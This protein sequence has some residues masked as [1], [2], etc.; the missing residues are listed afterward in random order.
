MDA[1]AIGNTRANTPSAAETARALQPVKGVPQSDEAKMAAAQNSPSNLRS[2]QNAQILQASMDVSIKSANTSL[3][4]LYRTAID[5]IN[6]VL[7]LSG[8]LEMCKERFLHMPE[9]V[10]RSQFINAVED[11]LREQGIL[12]V[13]ACITYAE[14]ED[15]YLTQDSPAFHS[16]L[17]YRQVARFHQCGFKF[18]RWYDMIWMEKHLGPHAPDQ[19]DPR[20]FA[21]VR[22]LVAAKYGIH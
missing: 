17:G 3:A 16:R 12:N 13:N 18:G 4:L 6:E 15:E 1:S 8:I 11:I 14:E 9:E 10:T 2:Q 20:P 19:P 5:R 7:T 22:P 21:A